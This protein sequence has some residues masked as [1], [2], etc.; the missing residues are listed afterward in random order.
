[1][2]GGQ[3][4]RVAIVR[5]LIMNPGIM[6]FDEPTSALDPELRGEVLKVIR[7]IAIGGRTSILVTHELRFAREIASHVVFMDG[8]VIVE[9][10]PPQQLLMEPR[11]ERTRNF[12]GRVFEQ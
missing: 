12:I 3:Q 7:D 10:G 6:L 11:E 2:S 1:L 8:G 9:Q 4:Q 5:S